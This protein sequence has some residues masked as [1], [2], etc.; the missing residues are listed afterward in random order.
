MRDESE[1]DSSATWSIDKII[2]RPFIKWNYTNYEN[3]FNKLRMWISKVCIIVFL[4]Q[5]QNFSICSLYICGRSMYTVFWSDQI[6]TK[7]HIINLWSHKQSSLQNLRWGIVRILLLSAV[8]TKKKLVYRQIDEK[9][10]EVLR[11]PELADVVS[12]TEILISVSAKNNM[13]NYVAVCRFI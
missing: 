5:D 2:N 8:Q 4:I 11:D 6:I 12:A 1:D 7:Q 3:L 10:I 9:C 13:K